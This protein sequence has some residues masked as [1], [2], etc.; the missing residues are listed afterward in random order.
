MHAT[1]TGI[2]G[3]RVERPYDWMTV[4]RG[5][6]SA[7][8]GAIE[9]LLRPIRFSS[10]GAIANVT[11]RITAVYEQRQP[12][13][14][15]GWFTE[16][17]LGL[18]AQ[19][20]SV[21]LRLGNLDDGIGNPGGALEHR[22]GGIRRGRLEAIGA[23]APVLDEGIWPAIC[24]GRSE[25]NSVMRETFFIVNLPSLSVIEPAFCT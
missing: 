8:A 7:S 19:V 6:A 22:N 16:K 4:P 1:V 5:P 9:S 17:D 15:A 18:V 20:G 11:G 25:K 3:G 21:E 23:L 13:T 24:F 14:F 2:L 10:V 12:A